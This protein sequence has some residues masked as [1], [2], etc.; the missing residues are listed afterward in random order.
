M[1]EQLL[2]NRLAEIERKANELEMQNALL[3][4]QA[5]MLL[6][7]H[8]VTPTQ[9]TAFISS[10][11]NFTPS[12]W[13]TLQQEKMKREEALARELSNIVSPA[14]NKKSLKALHL[15]SYALFVK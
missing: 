4:E 15:P 14:K 2:E 7:E 3:D 12:N 11:E 10:P 9:L 13:E 8:H 1:S 6:E 5:H